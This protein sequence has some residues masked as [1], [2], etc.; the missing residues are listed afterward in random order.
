MGSLHAP[1]LGARR[2]QVQPVATR[3]HSVLL[4]DLLDPVNEVSGKKT[5]F[6]IKHRQRWAGR[7]LLLPV[8]SSFECSLVAEIASRASPIS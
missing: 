3:S 5:G 2:S 8:A 6:D 7:C 1:R 4:L